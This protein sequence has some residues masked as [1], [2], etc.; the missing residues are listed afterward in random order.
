VLKKIIAIASLFLLTACTTSTTVTTGFYDVKGKDA[1]SL[2]RSI[3]RNSPQN[4][5]AFALTELRMAPVALET[6]TD[7]RGCR[8]GTAKI[9]VIANI[10]LPR[11]SERGGAP[12]DLKRGFDNYAA[13]AKAHERAHVQI[14][15]AA[16]RAIETQ[17]RAIPPQTDCVKLQRRVR[18]VTK[19]LL[20]IHHRA[21][22]AF[23]ASEKRRINALLRAASKR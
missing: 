1:T 9:K 13:Y 2:D 20:T 22:L 4:G 18:S 14:G 21:Q 19:R 16:A 6:R 17:V 12:S 11:W 3:R 23:D 5:H 15:E 10:I 8:I 7:A